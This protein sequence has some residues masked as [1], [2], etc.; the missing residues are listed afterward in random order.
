MKLYM[1]LS[2]P[3]RSCLCNGV[4]MYYKYFQILFFALIYSL[5]DFILVG[6][7]PFVLIPYMW[8]HYY[9]YISHFDQ[10]KFA[11]QLKITFIRKNMLEMLYQIETFIIGMLSKKTQLLLSMTENL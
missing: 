4:C 7:V 5:G 8:V 6:R 2:P 9:L 11:P 10:I 1:L 3:L